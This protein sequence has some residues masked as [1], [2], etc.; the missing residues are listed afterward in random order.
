MDFNALFIFQGMTTFYFFITAFENMQSTNPVTNIPRFKI[1]GEDIWLYICG[2]KNLA[3]KSQKDVAKIRE[4][5]TNIE[6]QIESLKATLE[7]KKLLGASLDDLAKETAEI[8][9]YLQQKI[10]Q[11]QK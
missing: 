1:S 8:A 7:V 11:F 4:M 10:D 9:A 5:K 2:A 6:R 3:M